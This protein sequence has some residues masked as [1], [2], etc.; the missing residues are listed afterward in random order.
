MSG[1]SETG[2][3]E[4][5]GQHL[6]TVYPPAK[7]HGGPGVFGFDSDS[8]LD[9]SSHLVS[10]ANAEKLFNEWSKHWNLNKPVLIEKSPPNLVRA[11]FLQALFPDAH[12]LMVLRHPIAVSYAT[13][14]WSDTRPHSLVKHWVVCHEQ[15]D[16]DRPKLK[17]L[18]VIRYEDFV[19]HPARTLENIWRF[20]GI[21]SFSTKRTIRT[22][23]NDKYFD[24]WHRLR[25]KDLIRKLYAKYIIFRYEKRVQKFGYSLKV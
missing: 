17:H 20:I 18:L 16:R 6:Q 25:N 12:F 24:H 19:R 23:I 10:R 4:D 13:R 15:F 22:G 3:V 2:V 8:F 11:R 9:E 7:V 21:E 14:K 1:F 5:E